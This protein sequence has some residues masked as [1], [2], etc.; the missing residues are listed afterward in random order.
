[1]MANP[2]MLKQIKKYADLTANMSDEEFAAALKDGRLNEFVGDYVDEV[3][4]M[5]KH[6][7]IDGP[8]V[9]GI[10]IEA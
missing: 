5:M 10:A 6:T 7:S 8:H 3:E 9:E 1:M 2:E 4:T